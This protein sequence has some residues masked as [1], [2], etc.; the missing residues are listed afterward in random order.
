MMALDALRDRAQ[1]WNLPAAQ[2]TRPG[3][4]LKC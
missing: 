2:K 3:A 4:N 1:A